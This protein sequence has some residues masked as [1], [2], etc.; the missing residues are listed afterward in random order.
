MFKSCIFQNRKTITSFLMIWYEQNLL[1]FGCNFHWLHNGLAKNLHIKIN[2]KPLRI[3]VTYSTECKRRGGWRNFQK[4]QVKNRI[5]LP[6]VPTFLLS[7]DLSALVFHP[8]TPR[9]CPFA[10]VPYLAAL[11]AI[12]GFTG[13]HTLPAIFG[14]HRLTPSLICCSPCLIFCFL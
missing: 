5:R 6:L 11:G 10:V 7:D 9:F 3:S 4:E 1:T 2:L 13:R 8:P 12:F 14:F